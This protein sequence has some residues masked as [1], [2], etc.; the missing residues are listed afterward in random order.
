MIKFTAPKPSINMEKAKKPNLKEKNQ[1]LRKE[2]EEI[3]TATF[4]HL[5][6]V[7]GEKKFNEKVRK[8][9]KILAAGVEKRKA[10]LEAIKEKSASS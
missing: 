2:T 3:L 6:E 5:K 1:I 7:I 9:G 8:A 10:K 4:S